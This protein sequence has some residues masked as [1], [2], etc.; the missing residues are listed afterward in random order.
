MATLFAWT[1]ALRK[2][3]ELDGIDALGQF[4]D[5][6][7]A[8]AIATIE[9]GTMTKDLV[10]LWDGGDPRQGCHLPGV[11]PGH[12]NRAGENAVIQ[13]AGAFPKPSSL[14]RGRTVF[15]EIKKKCID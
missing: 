13:I 12:P 7:E 15:F 6:L 10:G 14:V 1:G 8:A 4:A 11:H 3:G 5:K 9:G 2:R